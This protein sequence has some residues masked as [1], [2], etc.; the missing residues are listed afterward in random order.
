MLEYYGKYHQVY[1]CSCTHIQDYHNNGICCKCGSKEL[2]AIVAR[3]VTP[4][5]FWQNAYWDV[6]TTPISDEEKK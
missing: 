1:Q 2:K 3:L 4:W 5:F 6:K